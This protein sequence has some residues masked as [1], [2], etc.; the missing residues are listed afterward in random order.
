M[1]P[2]AMGR[3]RSP[4]SGLWN[5]RWAHVSIPNRRVG[6]SRRWSRR[7]RSPPRP[8]GRL[9]RATRWV[10]PCFSTARSGPAGAPRS[11]RTRAHRRSR[12]SAGASPL[13][14]RS[15]AWS[16][17]RRG[18]LR[19]SSRLRSDELVHR[20]HE[21]MWLALP[22][23]NAWLRPRA[24]GWADPGY[25]VTRTRRRTGRSAAARGV[26]WG[27]RHGCHE[28]AMN[29][30]P[31]PRARAWWQSSPSSNAV[32]AARTRSSARPGTTPFG[33]QAAV[34]ASTE[35]PLWRRRLR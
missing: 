9:T 17:M 30:R 29:E 11:S 34:S 35:T 20:R 31:S 26:W 22:H 33:T 19:S 28:E 32:Y 2:G 16:S 27:T 8:G 13:R 1:R 14:S 23:R 7:A 21:R 5:H 25:G 18:R 10:R 3:R 4:R 12:G 15:R 6:R 24:Y